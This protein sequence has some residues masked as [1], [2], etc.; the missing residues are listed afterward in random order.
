MSVKHDDWMQ[1]ILTDIKDYHEARQKRKK[2][3]IQPWAEYASVSNHDDIEYE[4]EIEMGKRRVDKWK[5]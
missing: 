1:S 2:A 3:Q 5:D 4:K